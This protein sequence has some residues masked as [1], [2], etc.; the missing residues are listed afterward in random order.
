M[1][2]AA[3]ATSSSLDKKKCSLRKFIF[4][5]GHFLSLKT[6]DTLFQKLRELTKP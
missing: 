2:L 5:R 4:V 1:G 6:K 3:N